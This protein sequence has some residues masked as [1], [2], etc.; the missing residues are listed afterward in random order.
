MKK[1]FLILVLISTVL[2]LYCQKLII[3]DTI[4]KAGIYKTF[5]E[6]KHN[7]PSMGFY[8]KINP[9]ITRFEDTDIKI[10]FISYTL[11]VPKKEGQAIGKIFGFC[12]G[13]HVF[14]NTNYPKL[15]PEK[16]FNI[17]QLVGPYC[18]FENLDERTESNAGH[19]LTVY[20]IGGYILNI[21]NGEVTKLTVSSLKE[22]IKDNPK[23]LERFNNELNKETKLKDYFI[24]YLREM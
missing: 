23:L 20:Y 3:E 4:F 5:K 7:N 6:F 10:E 1:V 14:I 17:I 24:Q 9:V 18:Y 11:D 15:K 19:S 21:E 13:K 8:Y 22:I 2:S 12:D 16:K